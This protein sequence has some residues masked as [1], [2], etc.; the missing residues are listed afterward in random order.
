MHDSILRKFVVSEI[1]LHCFGSNKLAEF[2]HYE[3]ID[4]AQFEWHLL[5]SRAFLQ[6]RCEFL[7]NL[8]LNKP[9]VVKIQH[10]HILIPWEVRT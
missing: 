7:G 5:Q 3:I 8:P 4:P 9:A 10:F 6:C 1:Y 2:L